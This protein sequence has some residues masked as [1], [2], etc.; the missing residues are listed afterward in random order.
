MTEALN[1]ISY[2]KINLHLDIGNIRP[3]GFHEIY[4]FF[5]AISL[6]DEI[7]II[8]NKDTNRKNI[9]IGG[10][11]SCNSEN[12]LIYKAAALF[13]E[14]LGSHF[15][16]KFN[17][18]KVIPEGGGLGGGSS[19]AAAVLKALNTYFNNFF[20]KN[21]LK[22]I[23]AIIGSDIPFFLEESTIALV[24]GRGDIVKPLS[25]TMPEYQLLLVYPG[26][27]VKTADAYS[28]LDDDRGNNKHNINELD[29]S[30]LLEHPSRWKFSNSFKKSLEKRFEIY[31]RIFSV[32][33]NKADFYDIT[34]S[35]S[36]VYGVFTDKGN[37]DSAY[38]DMKRFCPKVWITNMVSRFS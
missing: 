13:M 9:E 18:N 27:N 26:F 16:V 34:G 12:N 19:N 22:K 28:W 37:L 29:N 35:G 14:K 30:M 1:T 25:I 15:S 24:T 2:A 4:S 38:S 21:D 8:I 20:S 32:F 7:Q 31:D 23:A 3:D 36:I 33:N 6:H 10:N 5:K 17:V 11:F